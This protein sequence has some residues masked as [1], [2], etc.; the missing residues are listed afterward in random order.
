MIS[1]K[2]EQT[3]APFLYKRMTFNSCFT[4]MRLKKLYDMNIKQGR[5]DMRYDKANGVT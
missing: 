5:D 3:V 2:R 1:P 4:K